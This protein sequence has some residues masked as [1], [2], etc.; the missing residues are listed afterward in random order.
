MIRQI[1]K[2]NWLIFLLLAAAVILVYA[3]SLT[4]DFVSDDVMGILKN[5]KIGEFSWSLNFPLT[6]QWAATYHLFGK[7]PIPFRTENILFHLANAWLVFIL[8][9]LL[10]QKKSVA[11]LTALIFSVHPI[12]TES[13]TWLSGGIYAKYTF[14]V[15]LA[16]L[17]YINFRIVP[18]NIPHSSALKP[19]L[20]RKIL[21][22]SL[23]LLS[24]L[25]ALTFSE[26]AMIFPGIIFIYEIAFGSLKK[27]WLKLTPYFLIS[28]G[29][30]AVNFFKLGQ[31]AASLEQ[32][33]YQS[34]ERAHPLIQIPISISY[35]LQLI[36]WPE[37]LSL[38]QTEMFFSSWE[39]W[40][41]LGITG[42]LLAAIIFLFI[43]I[44]IKKAS[45]LERHIFF[46]LSF[47]IIVLLPT[48][49]AFGLAWIV[50]ERYV[51]LA[52]LG[53]IAS[54]VL[55]WQ[56]LNEKFYETKKMFWIV[57]ILIVLALG[58]RTV[59]RNNDWKNQDTLWL[60]T[61]KVAPSGHVIHNNLGDMYGR[62]QQYDKSIAE[63]KT[64]IAIQP[65]YAD[66]MHNLA[67]TYLEI[68]KV[69]EAIYWYSQAIKFGPHL[70]Q[71]YQNL[72]AIYYQL[73]EL[74]KAE[75]LFAR[76]VEINPS[77]ENLR[78]NLEIIRSQKTLKH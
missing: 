14:F 26:K 9:F 4:N 62:W 10:T 41:R 23:S 6:F 51:Y 66:A 1:I 58:A 8:L 27:H 28:A 21:L 49:L 72:G 60:S 56:V 39:Y 32:D 75:E 22:I 61:V 53:I 67:N 7:N 25:T 57:G 59:T 44:I 64:A 65:N 45:V 29:W 18:H 19:T 5:E 43:R 13:V 70:W 50:A 36:F 20:K 77:D 16:L 73:G 40:L 78:K 52:S 2:Q 12:L 46:W 48:M 68:N 76:A 69:E 35:Y 38:Y 34:P 74:E 55:M 15:L 30:F 37:K 42:L 33:F 63:Y 31:R 17:F 11:L 47:F 24:F 71:S 3:N 54:F